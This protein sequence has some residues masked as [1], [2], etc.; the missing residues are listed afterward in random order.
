LANRREADSLTGS[1]QADFD[2]SLEE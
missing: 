1:E 2:D